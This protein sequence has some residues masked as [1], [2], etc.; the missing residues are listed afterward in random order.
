L[1]ALENQGT[2]RFKITVGILGTVALLYG[3]NF[4]IPC[5]LPFVQRYGKTWRSWGSAGLRGTG[6][7]VRK[8]D[9]P[10]WNKVKG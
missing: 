3:R 6:V 5:N 4:F 2:G 1:D 9:E 7:R 8:S 10:E